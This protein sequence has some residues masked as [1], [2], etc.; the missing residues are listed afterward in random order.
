M[1]RWIGGLIIVLHQ[2]D[3]FTYFSTCTKFI[4]ILSEW[5]A[6]HLV[7]RLLVAV[8]TLAALTALASHAAAHVAVAMRQPW[9]ILPADARS[10]RDLP[11]AAAL[12]VKAT[13][14]ALATAHSAAHTLVL[15]HAAAH[16]TTRLVCN[17]ST[18]R[19]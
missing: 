1:V 17:V 12:G 4:T 6:L 10:I 18:V 5:K 3:F 7:V 14:S 2:L 9:A 19:N 13:S 8:A 15:A 16:T 11:V